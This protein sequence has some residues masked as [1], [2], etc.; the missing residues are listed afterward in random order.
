MT[1]AEAFLS[2]GIMLSDEAG[3]VALGHAPTPPCY[4]AF[5]TK[6]L[7][8]ATS[9]GKI[10]AGIMHDIATTY[11]FARIGIN[12]ETHKTRVLRIMAITIVEEG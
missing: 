4:K 2:V 3:I 11:H 8:G 7:E 6:I 12:G 9:H 10:A 1:E 5:I